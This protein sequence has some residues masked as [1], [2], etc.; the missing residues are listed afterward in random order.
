MSD[1]EQGSVSFFDFFPENIV[2]KLIMRI[3]FKVA[4]KPGHYVIV[5][6]TDRASLFHNLVILSNILLSMLKVFCE[7]LA[8]DKSFV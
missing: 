1:D 8:A 5:F 3:R 6:F 4:W 2:Y 7:F